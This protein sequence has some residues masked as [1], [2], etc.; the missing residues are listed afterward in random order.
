MF[1]N[2]GVTDIIKKEESVVLSNRLTRNW[3]EISKSV[4]DYLLLNHHYPRESFCRKAHTDLGEKMINILEFVDKLF[5]YEILCDNMNVAKRIVSMY[6][7]NKC[8]LFCRYCYRSASA[9]NNEFLDFNNIEKVFEK[10]ANL[11]NCRTVV[12][13]GG[14]PLLHHNIYEILSLANDYFPNVILQTNGTLIKEDNINRIAEFVKKVRIGLDGATSDT[15]DF[16]R[17]KGSF[18]KIMNGIHLISS[19]GIPLTISTTIYKQ[20]MHEV[21]KLN[22][23][24]EQFKAEI[25]FT[26]FLPIG[27]GAGFENIGVKLNKENSHKSSDIRCG[28]FSKKISCDPV[29]NLYPCD[30]LMNDDFLIGNI[31]SVDASSIYENINI[32][33]LISRN[34]YTIQQCEACNNKFYCNALCPAK[35]YRTKG[36]IK[37]IDAD[38]AENIESRETSS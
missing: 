23:M 9:S 20:N 1:L 29:G 18:E 35:A 32:R 21:E 38:C 24:A 37:F 12:L 26:E 6:I 27:R 25:V 19:Y 13:T 33:E 30:E 2:W 36:S 4:Y 5:D 14:E 11:L 8:N 22:K 16:F 10:L 15:N 31:S 7:T 34:I 17:G 3:I 28:A